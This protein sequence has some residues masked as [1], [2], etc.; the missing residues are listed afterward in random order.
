M[1]ALTV[2]HISKKYDKFHLEDITFSLPSGSIMGLI[3]E[4]GAGKTTIINCII[5][6]IETDAGTIQILGVDKNKRSLSLREDIGIVFD[7]SDFY[8]N[9]TIRQVG[10]ILKD[11]YKRWDTD[12]YEQYIERF[13]LPNKKLI[14]EFSRGMKMKTAIAIALSYHPKLLVLDEAT[15]GLDPIMRDEILDV[16]LDFVQDEEHSI[17]IS[18]HITTDLEKIADYITFIHDGKLLLSTSKDT[19]LYDYGILKCREDSFE[20][21]AK[22]DIIRYRKHPYAIEILVK[23][24]DKLSH[25]YRDC[26]IDPAK[27]DDIMMLYVKGETL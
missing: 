14:K 15:S 5:S 12:A 6:M 23:N 27:L 10:N 8:D 26:I 25:K 16:F 20:K 18:S 24:R 11:V 2:E 13:K 3:G 9:F 19:L 1:D 7:V 4:N 21:I 17:L 22:E